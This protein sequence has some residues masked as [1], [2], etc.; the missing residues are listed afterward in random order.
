M[1]VINKKTL[2]HLAALARMELGAHEEEKL[3][4]DLEKILAHFEELKAVDTGAVLPL[5]GGTNLKSVTRG[6]A[7]RVRPLPA[8]AAVDAFPEKEGR[9]LKIPPVFE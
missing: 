7:E 3:L 8:D 6:D 2:E 9:Y 5:A 4:K 1:S